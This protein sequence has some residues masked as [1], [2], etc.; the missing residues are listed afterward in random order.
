MAAISVRNLMQIIQP[1]NATNHSHPDFLETLT[2]YTN[3]GWPNNPI[4][5]LNQTLTSHNH[6]IQLLLTSTLRSNLTIRVPNGT[7]THSQSS[8]QCTN[9]L[10]NHLPPISHLTTNNL[11]HILP[12]QYLSITINQLTIDP[13]Q[14]TNK[15]NLFNIIINITTL[16]MTPLTLLT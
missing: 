13:N 6:T 16:P 5:P 8:T 10:T 12:L 14:I 9:T 1:N 3:N 15:S 11:L 4:H 7:L 2:Y